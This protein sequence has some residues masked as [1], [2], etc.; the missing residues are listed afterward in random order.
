M[1]KKLRL[2][3]NLKLLISSLL[4]TSVVSFSQQNNDLEV[5]SPDDAIS[6]RV[7]AGAK[8]Q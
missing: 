4:A 8:L 2:H 1:S 3:L 5:Q 6:V 7:S